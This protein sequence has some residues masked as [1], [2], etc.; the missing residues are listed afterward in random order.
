M[1]KCEECGAEI[2][3]GE[4]E[5]GKGSRNPVSVL[6]YF[7]PNCDADM[8]VDEVGNGPAEGCCAPFAYGCLTL[9][10]VFLIIL[11]ISYLWNES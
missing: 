9:M 2:K 10:V 7:C 3:L 1:S 5:G 6:V 8:G 4:R 11:F